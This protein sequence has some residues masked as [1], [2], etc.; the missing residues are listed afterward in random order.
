M[1][2]RF[3]K[4]LMGQFTIFVV[5]I[6]CLLIIMVT[7]SGNVARNA[8][9]RNSVQSNEMIATQ[10]A[11]RMEKFYEDVRNILSSMIYSP[12]VMDY[13]AA[14]DTERVL[15]R[16]D[17][18]SMLSNTT[19]VQQNVEGIE[20]YDLEGRLLY[21]YGKMNEFKVDIAKIDTCTF[22]EL[23]SINE[24][25]QFY[26]SVTLPIYEIMKESYG[27]KI[28]VCKVLMNIKNFDDY[29]ENTQ[30][31]KTSRVI[32]TDSKGRIA[33]DRQKEDAGSFLTGIEEM[34]EN[35]NYIIDEKVIGKMGWNVTTI[36][37]REELLEE[38]NEVKLFNT[39]TYVLIG[40]FI[41][42]FLYG[43]YWSLIKPVRN[44]TEF[45]KKHVENPKRRLNICIKNE[46]KELAEQLNN[47]LD[48]RDKR[49]NELKETENRIYELEIHQK[50]AE[51]LAYQNQI[52]PHFLYNTFEC[53]CSMAYYHEEKEIM[54]VTMVLSDMFRYFTKGD[55]FIPIKEEIMHI[56]EYGTII[57]YRFMGK[58]R[59]ETE[60]EKGVENCRI[61]KLLLQPIVENAVFHGL[62]RIVEQGHVLV[63]AERCNDKKL[64]F[65]ISDNG[66]GMD[67]ETLNKLRYKLE[68]SESI[69]KIAKG[70][71]GIGLLSIYQRLKL[72]YG[73]ESDFH[74]TSKLGEGTTVTI[75]IPEVN[76]DDEDEKNTTSTIG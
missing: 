63:R 64:C 18:V 35:G 69:L 57:K 44:I 5:I 70:N 54:E 21:K 72:I 15:M 30:M 75:I 37:P 42:I 50:Q 65:T 16:E 13:Y 10:L 49:E 59:V 66:Y 34:K 74:I 14:D 46:I 58:I 73:E 25:H 6:I 40:V 67:L 33:A 47:M 31:T 45:A 1:K 12:T 9:E 43:T 71:H 26:Y 24:N 51:L 76:T 38:F 28:G 20:L 32:F 68:H 4:T 41:A 2:K 19:T 39:I 36:I 53:I 3:I 11:E 56:M 29:L 60:I 23:Y 22:S 61:V 48:D 27:N 55:N 17:L 7:I 8:I 62:E 52:N